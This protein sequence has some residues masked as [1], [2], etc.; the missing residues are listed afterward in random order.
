MAGGELKL[1]D[2]FSRAEELHIV[3]R[4]WDGARHKVI[5]RELNRTP[6][7]IDQKIARMKVEGRL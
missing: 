2:R 4:K 3:S 7:A 6:G 5:A 1:F